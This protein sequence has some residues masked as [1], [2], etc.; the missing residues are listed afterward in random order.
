MARRAGAGWH[1][2]RGRYA[3]M[4]LA[5]AAL[6]AASLVW[7]LNALHPLPP[8]AVSLATGPD[9]SAYAE[10][11]R[12]YQELLAQDGIRVTLV[13]TGGGVENA[14]LLAN[15][16]SGIHLGFVDGG[17]GPDAAGLVSLGTVSYQPLWFFARGTAAGDGFFALT[18][19][20]LSV[21]PEGSETRAL[22]LELLKLNR[23]DLKSID[24]LAF[25]PAEAAEQLLEG[26]I[27]AAAMVT[28]WESPA[29][30]RLLEADEVHLV[31]F[32]RADAYI[33]RYP[34]LNRLVVPMGVG[35]LAKN[36]PPND[37]TVLATKASFV[38]REDLHPALQYLLM[39]TA[40]QI[41]SKAG[42]FQR[43]GQFPAAEPID[44]A[45]SSHARHFYR[46][47]RPFLQRWFPFWLAVI[48]E[49]VLVVILPV[50]GVAYPVAKG[51]AALYEWG[52]KR[53]IL[54]VYGELWFLHNALEIAEDEQAKSRLLAQLQ[55]LQ[56][57]AGRLRVSSS[58]IPL[59]YTLRNHIDVVCRKVADQ[60]HEDGRGR[61]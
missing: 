50:L 20:R 9:G 37:V 5:F 49:Q 48:V 54:L 61:G 14:A 33:A 25:S 15:P 56:N 3:V 34:Y 29:V 57:R 4:I 10:F 36:L 38:V 26:R 32:S 41:H 51:L 23:I 28:S 27:D 58:F 8:R 18:A 31:S 39:E 30:R 19:R 22:A 40:A 12:R 13:P 55:R 60:Q 21:G 59:L 47:G 35:D 11:G 2:R 46:S 44:V 42:I 17:V 52:V 7:L 1:L 16:H 6:A 43:P 45:L 24:L 53:R